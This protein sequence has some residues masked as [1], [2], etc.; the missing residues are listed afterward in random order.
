MTIPK[1]PYTM[2][3]HAVLA[4]VIILVGA[5]ATAVTIRLVIKVRNRKT[6][7][8]NKVKQSGNKVGG[9]QAGRDVNK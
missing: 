9:D 2:S 4:L 5:A 1:K 8:S 7:K 3:E 6:D